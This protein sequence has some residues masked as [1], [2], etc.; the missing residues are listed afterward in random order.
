MAIEDLRVI[1][2]VLY[3]RRSDGLLYPVRQVAGQIPAQSEPQ[4]PQ[5]LLSG[6]PELGRMVNT[7]GTFNQM[8][9]PV[10]GIGQSMGASQRMFAP[11]TSTMDRIAALGDMLSGVAGVTAPIGAAV[12]AGTPAAVALMEGL[13]GGSPTVTAARDTARSVARTV[14]ERAN[15]RG[16]VPVMGSNFANLLGDVGEASTGIRAYHGSP[17]SFDKFSMDKIGTGEGA[18]A[19]GHGLY[20]AENEGIARGYRDA[21]TDPDAVSLSFDGRPV[22][23]PWNNEIRERWPEYF[24]KLNENDADAMEE[25]LGNLSQVNNMADVKNVLDGVSSRAKMLY[26]RVVKPKLVKPDIKAGSVYEVNINANPD[27]FIN[28]DAPL[29][30]QGQKVKEQFG[31]TPKPTPDEE[32]AAYELAKREAPNNIGEHPAVQDIYRRESAANA[33]ER[34]FQSKVQG[35]GVD[36]AARIGL[37]QAGIPGIKYFD[38][39]SRGAASGTRNFVVFDDNLISIV[40]KYGIAGAAAMLGVSAVDVEEAMARG[41]QQPPQGLLSMG[42]K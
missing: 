40:R 37:S 13:L 38:A 18:Q 33:A 41:Q 14:A 30:A 36:E 39:G 22:N 15:Q 1:G 19:Y 4:A 12:R 5:G 16:P 28:Y 21:L 8:F 35:G 29:S 7:L 25:L 32:I 11:D 23:T 17:H 2:N 26:S 27:D 34:L 24:S 42:S 3:E 6:I 9:N 31:Y 20:F 10:E